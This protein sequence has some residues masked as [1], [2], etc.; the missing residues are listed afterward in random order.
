MCIFPSD[1]I[2]RIRFTGQ[3]C[4]PISAGHPAP[5]RLIVLRSRFIITGFSEKSILPT[6]F[7]D[8]HCRLNAQHFQIIPQVDIGLYRFPVLGRHY[9]FQH[10]IYR[11]H[12]LVHT[13]PLYTTEKLCAILQCQAESIAEFLP[14]E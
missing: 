6:L 4:S 10:Q 14:D 1:G 9:S 5:R 12:L 11:L 8:L 13:I 7:F 2:S 3:G